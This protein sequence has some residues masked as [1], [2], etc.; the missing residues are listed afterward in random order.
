[1]AKLL[2]SVRSGKEARWALAGGASIIDVKDPDRGSLG[3][4]SLAAWREVRAA[5]G[6]AAPI[7]V[8]LGELAEWLDPD[9]PVL[10]GDAWAGI[11]YR[12]LG[13]AGAGSGWCR[14]WGRLRP[15]LDEGGP[16][17]IAVIYNDW[18]K[19][20][21]PEPEAVVDAA[22]E[23]S[24]I[25]GVLIDTWDKTHRPGLPSAARGWIE[26]VRG[27]GRVVAIAGG[28]DVDAVARLEAFAPDIVAVRGAACVDGDRRAAIDPRRVAELAEVVAALPVHHE[29]S[30]NFTPC[31]RGSSSP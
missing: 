25:V 9:S 16:G 15:R 5:V 3:R 28:L 29:P 27:E 7:S 18:R 30:S 1:V 2:V 31:A 10:P 23:S 24:T 4:A 14:D 21:A 8:A 26:R 22:L 11:S 12:K 17:W 20:R 6:S 13:L 19:A